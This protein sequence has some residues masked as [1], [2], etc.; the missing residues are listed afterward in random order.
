MGWCPPRG[1]WLMGF[2]LLWF[3]SGLRNFP[4]STCGGPSAPA[5]SKGAAG[6]REGATRPPC[7]WKLPDLDLCWPHGSF[8][9]AVPAFRLRKSLRTQERPCRY[10]PRRA[11]PQQHPRTVSPRGFH[12]GAWVCPRRLPAQENRPLW[13][14][15]WMGGLP[16]GAGR[17][18]SELSLG[19]RG[20]PRGGR[21]PGSRTCGLNA[22][23]TSVGVSGQIWGLWGHL[24]GR[25][26]SP[27]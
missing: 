5:G 3:S 24:L 11:S 22:A 1:A 12:S 6:R 4:T 27:E 21:G 7:S 10:G 16:P 15:P 20:A 19:P 14:Q 2:P 18:S 8:V 17:V 25:N 13:G 26:L 9:N 23:L